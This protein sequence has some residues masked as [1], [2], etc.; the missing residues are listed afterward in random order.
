[1]KKAILSIFIVTGL[2][3]CASED[4]SDIQEW[5]N[6]QEKELKGKIEVLQPAK[7]FTPTPYNASIDPF[8]IREKITLKN[9]VK[10]KYSPDLNREKEDLENYNLDSLRMIGTLIKDGKFY[11]MIKDPTNVI[12]YVTIGNFMGKN[13]GQIISISE[14]EIVLDERI[15]A[16]E[17]WTQNINKKFLYEGSQKK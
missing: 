12:N 1:M 13:Y 16:N 2:T 5:M 6:K 9:L 4:H 17:E 11:A 15:K 3:A 14:G 8:A 10:D 7:S